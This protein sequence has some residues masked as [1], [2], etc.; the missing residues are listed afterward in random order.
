MHR[1][2]RSRFVENL[3]SF[4]WQIGKIQSLHLIEYA[5]YS[6]IFIFLHKQSLQD[7]FSHGAGGRTEFL[8]YFLISYGGTQWFPN[9]ISKSICSSILILGMSVHLDT[10]VCKGI[11]SFQPLINNCKN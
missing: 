8:I 3:L 1:S 11:F 4:L 6:V 5:A 2:F 7:S 10:K 9:R